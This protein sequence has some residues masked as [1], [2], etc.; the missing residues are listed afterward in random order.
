MLDL[1]I[2]A[3]EIRQI[4][5]DKRKEFGLEFF[6]DNHKYNMKGLDGELRSD[7]PSVSKLLKNFYEEFPTE[8]AALKKAKG[9]YKEAERLK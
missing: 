1:K 3:E 4:L 7:F 6:E 9:D 2:A 5:D 8:E